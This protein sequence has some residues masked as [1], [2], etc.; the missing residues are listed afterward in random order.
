MEVDFSEEDDF[1][2]DE[3]VDADPESLLELFEDLSSLLE[4]SEDDL[5][6]FSLL[7]SPLELPLLAATSETT[8]ISLLED[9]L[10]AAELEE[11]ALCCSRRG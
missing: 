11:S 1:P 8:A 7:D 5:L 9:A 3:V 10:A 6:S 2:E 4:S